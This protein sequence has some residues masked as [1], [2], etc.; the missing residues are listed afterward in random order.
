MP[1]NGYMERHTCRLFR[2]D[3]KAH[4]LVQPGG[5][6][7]Q[8]CARRVAIYRLSVITKRLGLAI[9]SGVVFWRV[10][11]YVT[12]KYHAKTYL[13]SESNRMGSTFVYRCQI[14]LPLK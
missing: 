3:V 12:R 9:L 8:V 11:K 13:S 4:R 6:E 2:Q 10:L 5:T 1:S 7:P 14:F